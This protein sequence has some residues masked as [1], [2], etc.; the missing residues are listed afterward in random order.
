M[1]RK[2]HGNISNEIPKKILH[3]PK[4]IFSPFLK[5]VTDIPDSILFMRNQKNKIA[6]KKRNKR[7]GEEERR[8]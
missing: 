6:A 5:V 7:K 8:Q 2:A 1:T 3:W 4:N